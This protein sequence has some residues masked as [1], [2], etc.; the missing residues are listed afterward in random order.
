MASSQFIL[1]IHRFILFISIISPG[2]NIETIIE[3]NEKMST[4]N[5]G[6]NRISL[7]VLR[8]YPLHP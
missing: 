5:L 6:K 3:M 2:W 7:I 8:I 1:F 4:Q